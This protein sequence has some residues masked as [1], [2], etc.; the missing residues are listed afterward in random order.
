MTHPHA[1]FLYSQPVLRIR[2]FRNEDLGGSNVLETMGAELFDDRLR[3]EVSLFS[4]M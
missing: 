3:F 1:K 2:D 4:L